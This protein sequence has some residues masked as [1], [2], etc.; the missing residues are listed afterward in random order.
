MKHL[1]LTLILALSTWQ[2]FAIDGY[3]EDPFELQ[4][5]I[6]ANENVL[7]IFGASWCGPCQKMKREVWESTD[8]KSFTDAN[9][10]KR[11]YIDIDLNRQL[12]EQYQITSIPTWFM[13]SQG[14]VMA[15][16]GFANMQTVRT[17]ISTYAVSPTIGEPIIEEPIV[18]DP[19]PLEPVV[20]YSES[21]AALN[22]KMVNAEGNLLVI[23]SATWCGPCQRMKRD[24]WNVQ[25]FIDFANSLGTT[26]FHFDIDQHS[27]LANS[28]GVTSIPTWYVVK[29]GSILSKNSSASKFQVERILRTSFK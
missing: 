24:V 29:D 11:F 6:A 9:S 13:I 3:S 27:S 10:V 17:I 22:E 28:W 1:L 8:F 4:N 2:V 15:R 26:K 14:Q 19:V 20:E 5:S 21:E 25:D 18:Q 12:T 7:L 23:F 16:T